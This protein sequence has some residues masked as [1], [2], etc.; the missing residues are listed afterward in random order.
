MIAALYDE[1]LRHHGLSIGIK[2]ARKHLGWALDAAAATAG[3]GEDVR[4]Q[5][6]NHV[7]TATEPGETARRLG[8]AFDAFG[9]V[10]AFLRAPA[11]RSIEAD[12][13]GSPD[14]KAAA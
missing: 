10:A 7:L 4:R 14:A 2:H 6:R 3:A 9:N 5:H 8:E 11:L 12:D 1:M 13:A